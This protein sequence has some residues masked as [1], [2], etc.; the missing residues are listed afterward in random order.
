M[1]APS[2][3]LFGSAALLGRLVSACGDPQLEPPDSFTQRRSFDVTCEPEASLDAAT[4]VSRFRLIPSGSSLSVTAGA[5]IYRGELTDY[6]VARIRA[7]EPPSTLAERQVPSRSWREEASLVVAPT[8]ALE[9]GG[10]YTLI[11]RSGQSVRFTVRTDDERPLLARVW[12]P[13]EA[14]AV[15]PVAVYCGD[16]VVLVASVRTQLAPDGVSAL[17]ERGAAPGVAV[18]R[19]L[20]LSVTEA[21]SAGS[22]FMPPPVVDGY[23]ID[24]APLD[25]GRESQPSRLQCGSGLVRAGP[26]CAEIADDRFTLQSLDAPLFWAIGGSGVDY[27]QA[28]EASGRAVV[29]GLVPNES[30]EL[31]VRAISVGGYIYDDVFTAETHAPMPHVVINEVLADPAGPEPAQEWVELYND[32][33]EQAVIEGW[34]FEDTGGSVAL[35]AKSIPAGAYL[36]LVGEDFDSASTADVPPREGTTLLGVAGLGKNGLSNTGEPLTL[37]DAAGRVVS[38][39]PALPKPKTG[40]SV[41]RRQPWLE[42]DDPR[43]FAYHGG[44]GSSP[45]GPNQVE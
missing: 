7:G 11:V 9:A 20:Q 30:M 28:L 43:S 17:V 26:G 42:D 34:T 44:V 3:A 35:D 40:V 14:Q 23:L 15:G 19:C 39:F 10:Q 16:Q 1:K 37:R 36:L 41:A 38:R 22:W 18:G 24:P 31:R 6:Y 45:G 21:V 4:R 32:G 8:V 29:R 25:I 5:E 33:L 12:P 2:I 13:T 27:A